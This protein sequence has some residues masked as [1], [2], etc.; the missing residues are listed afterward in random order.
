MVLGVHFG[1]G[2]NFLSG[3]R[4]CYTV[5]HTVFRPLRH[6]CLFVVCDTA[7]WT[8]YAL[9]MEPCMLLNIIETVRNKEANLEAVCFTQAIIVQ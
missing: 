3:V 7:E 6:I 1:I 9:A 2:G 5:E 8:L 4:C